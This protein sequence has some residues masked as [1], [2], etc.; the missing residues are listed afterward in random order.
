MSAHPPPAL[1]PTMETLAFCELVARRGAGPCRVSLVRSP[2]PSPAPPRREFLEDEAEEVE[3]EEETGGGEAFRSAGE[4]CIRTQSPL[5]TS[6]EQMKLGRLFATK[7][8]PT[9][10]NHVRSR[11][12]RAMKVHDKGDPRGAV[13]RDAWDRALFAVLGACA[14]PLPRSSAGQANRAWAVAVLKLMLASPP[15]GFSGGV[16]AHKDRVPVLACLKLCNLRSATDLVRAQRHAV[17]TEASVRFDDTTAAQLRALTQDRLSEVW[18]LKRAA[19][20]VM[21]EMS[22]GKGEADPK[23]SGGPWVVSEEA[24]AA[25]LVQAEAGRA[26]WK[27]KRGGRSART[28]SLLNARAASAFQKRGDR[29]GKERMGRW[30]TAILVAEHAVGDLQGALRWLDGRRDG[31]GGGGE[32]HRGSGGGWGKAEEGES[33][34]EDEE[35]GEGAETPGEGAGFGV[36]EQP[37]LPFGLPDLGVHRTLQKKEL[38]Q[39]DSQFAVV[40]RDHGSIERFAAGQASGS[41]TGGGDVEA[42]TALMWAVTRTLERGAVAPPAAHMRALV[43]AARPPCLLGE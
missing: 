19:E 10:M 25:M 28:S 38:E 42:G 12:A 35:G 43:A 11:V 3:E 22:A 21:R 40:S 17:D 37:V 36:G 26:W 18:R 27:P 1:S 6:A 2:L 34:G 8:L 16:F 23:V 20:W 33:L 7:A 29:D 9:W 39:L 24:W 32:R 30:A 14:A 5:V 13:V 15:G 41:G 4:P 31:T